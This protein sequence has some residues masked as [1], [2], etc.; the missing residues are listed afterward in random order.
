MMISRVGEKFLHIHQHRVN[1]FCVSGLARSI[2]YH[3]GLYSF[4]I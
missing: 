3:F 4:G 2:L 1:P